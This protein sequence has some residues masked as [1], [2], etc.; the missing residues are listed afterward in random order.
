MLGKPSAYSEEPAAKT[1]AA[2]KTIF[3]KM[4]NLKELGMR[5]QDLRELNASK[6]P[7]MQTGS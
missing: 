7:L 2:Y 1:E 5:Q 3:K 4:K 6:Q